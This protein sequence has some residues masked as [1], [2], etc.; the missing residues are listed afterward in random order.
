MVQDMSYKFRCRFWSQFVQIFIVDAFLLSPINYD[1]R[2]LYLLLLQKHSEI[3]VS[4]FVSKNKLVMAQ[5]MP[6]NPQDPF[7]YLSVVVKMRIIGSKR[8]SDILRSVAVLKSYQLLL[9]DHLRAFLLY[10][11][12]LVSS[13][14]GCQHFRSPGRKEIIIS[15]PKYGLESSKRSAK[16]SMW[17]TLVPHR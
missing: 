1:S 10:S 11:F 15:I 13:Q 6:H 3:V 5:G 12:T 8:C 17:N 16:S 4:I 14:S 7:W 2:G 9:L